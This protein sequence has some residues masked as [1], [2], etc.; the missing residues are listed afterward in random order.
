MEFSSYTIDDRIA[1]V[2]ADLIQVDKKRAEEINKLRVSATVQ[3]KQNESQFFNFEKDFVL[4]GGDDNMNAKEPRWR[5]DDT[6]KKSALENLEKLSQALEEENR[7]V[8]EKAVKNE[9]TESG[10]LFLLTAT[11]GHV[12]LA[13]IAYIF[14]ILYILYITIGMGRTY[15]NK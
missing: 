9:T 3:H 5:K 2:S 4:E 1:G 15:L 13:P 12:H 10:D 7:L 6:M 14:L 8:E 11:E